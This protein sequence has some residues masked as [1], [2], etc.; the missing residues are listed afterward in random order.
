MLSIGYGNGSRDNSGYAESSTDT[1]SVNGH[2]RHDVMF[3]NTTWDN[4]S[5]RLYS[6]RLHAGSNMITFTKLT[7]YTE[8]DASTCTERPPRTAAVSTLRC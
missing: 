5:T 4:W 2:K 6:V 3:P 8:L 1:V 7:F